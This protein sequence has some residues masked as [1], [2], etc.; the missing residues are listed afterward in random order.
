MRNIVFDL[1][2]TLVDSLP[3]IEESARIAITR[4]LPEVEMPDLRALIGPPIAAMFSKLWPDL[5]T[6]RMEDLLR[7]FR[8]HYDNEGCLLSRA[9]P[10][11]HEVLSGLKNAGKRFFVLTNKPTGPSK[12]ILTHL[13][14][15]G[16]F[17]E[18]IGPDFRT[19]SFQTK[20]EGASL[21]ME[22]YGLIPGETVIIGD[23]IDDAE[24][25]RACG[26]SFIAVSYGYGGAAAHVGNLVSHIKMF[27]EIE[28][29]L[30]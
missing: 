21:L 3:G 24:A 13:Q 16:F 1:D 4:V 23:G 28:Q 6:K 8:S 11:V 12:K 30:L 26:F 25:A 29:I 2:G 27:S 22:K 15:A 19:P 20:T 7:E 5:E 18:I 17:T 14:L 10:Q 9:Y